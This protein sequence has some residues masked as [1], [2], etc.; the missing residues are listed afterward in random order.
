M[1][2]PPRSRQLLSGE[3]P[4]ANSVYC[5]S[6]NRSTREMGNNNNNNK[7]YRNAP[8]RCLYISLVLFLSLGSR[9]QFKSFK[10]DDVD[11]PPE[12]E[13]EEEK[14]KEEE[15]KRSNGPPGGGEQ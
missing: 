8:D 10:D 14:E 1:I 6:I 11:G 12:E 2:F 7:F 15:E 4:I 9:S 3:I 13:E 5:D